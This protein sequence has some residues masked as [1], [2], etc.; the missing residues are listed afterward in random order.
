M[1]GFVAS[2]REIIYSLSMAVKLPPK[3]AISVF[4]VSTPLLRAV[5]I[6]ETTSSA[7]G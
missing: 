5:S 3:N 7:F 2:K 1:Y 4:F 6:A